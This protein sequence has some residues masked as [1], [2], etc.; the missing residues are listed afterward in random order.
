M[1]W[2]ELFNTDTIPVIFFLLSAAVVSVIVVISMQWRKV[3][4]A[5]AEAALKTRMIDKG[6]SAAEIAKVCQLR[7][8][9]TPRKRSRF[10]DEYQLGCAC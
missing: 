3:R 8:V 1:N 4:I 7:I 10:S 9:V 2:N 5:E 6:Y